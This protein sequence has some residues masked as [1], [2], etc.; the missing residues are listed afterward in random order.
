MAG[1]VS[2]AHPLHST[3]DQGPVARISVIG[4]FQLT[5][6]GRHVLLSHSAE[7]VVAYLAL[8]GRPVR[9]SR[10]AGELWPDV[11]EH[12][13]LGNLRSALWRRPDADSPLVI[14]G[15]D[16]LMLARGTSID[17]SELR[18]LADA[19]RLAPA[20]LD[21]ASVVELT[22]AV[23]IL[24]DWEEDWLQPHR[25]QFREL[26]LHALDRLCEHFIAG[27]DYAH[28]IETGMVMVGADPFRE[29][30][31]R[32]LVR[33]YL[34]EGNVAD[35]MRAYGTYRELLHDELD[36]VPSALMEQVIAEIRIVPDRD[37]WGA[38][39]VPASV[40]NR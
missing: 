31:R 2:G 7:R 10:L 21:V 28:A 19:A 8:A 24:G 34:G 29:T 32:Q 40:S 38:L 5:I 20:S 26:W 23:D 18:A 17:L 33:A 37:G 13:A 27:G 16:Q 3:L 9:R 30:P 1:S 22:S 4:A 25:D 15:R 11:P 39:P 6:A 14:G 35:A 12:R 36:V